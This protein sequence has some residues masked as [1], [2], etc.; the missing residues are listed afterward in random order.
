MLLDGGLPDSQFDRDVWKMYVDSHLANLIL[1]S[2]PV[3]AQGKYYLTNTRNTPKH[4][5]PNRDI[6]AFI[7]FYPLLVYSYI[8]VC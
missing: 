5:Q 8:Q 6:P 2:V 1:T 4:P 3:P 7:F